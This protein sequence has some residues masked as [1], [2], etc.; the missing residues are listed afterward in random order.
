[1]KSFVRFS[2][3]K[4]KFVILF[5]LLVMTV[6][7]LA[8]Q[9]Q[10]GRLEG[11]VF[12]SDGKP[13]GNITV[14]VRNSTYGT[15]TDNL[16]NF[17]FDVPVGEHVL[18]IFSINAHTIEY[19]VTVPEGVVRIDGIY[20]R[21]T[22]HLLPA[23]VVTG[24][25]SPQSLRSSVYKVRVITNDKIERKSAVDV[26]S[27]LNTEIGIR[28]NNDQTLGETD[29]EVMGMSGNNIK[30]LMDGVPLIDRGDAKQSLSQV[31][32]NSI[33]RI[34]I[35]E[36]PMSVVYGTDALA[37]VVNII[38]KRPSG[39]TT[40]N[41]VSVSAGFQEESVGR[42]YAFF[43]GKG[44][45]TENIYL[46]WEGINGIYA[47]TGFTRN[48][49][50]G[51]RGD[52]SGQEKEW[53]PKSQFLYTGMTGYTNRKLDVWYKLDFVDEKINTPSN[54]TSASPNVVSNKKFLTHRYTNQLHADYRA[55]NRL[56]FNFAASY[57][58]YRRVT[59]TIITDQDTN[60]KWLSLAESSQ[61]TSKLESWF[62][63]LTASW[64]V[65][66]KIK[67]QPGIEYQW[68][69]AS[70]DRV[71][72]SPSISDL[73]IFILAEWTPVEWWNLRPG[74]RSVIISDY[75]A[76]VAI[77]ALLTKL[78]ITDRMDFR[79]SYAY[80]FRAPALRELYFSFHN[81]NHN[82]DGNPDLKSE[83]SHNFTASFTWRPIHNETV[84]LTSSFSGFYNSFKDRITL[85]VDM[86]DPQHMTYYNIDKYRT[87]GGTIENVLSWNNLRV[88]LGISIIGRYNT[89]Y[90]DQRYDAENMDRL[91][92]SPEV[93]AS[94]AYSFRRGTDI[95]FF[96]KFTGKRREYYVDDYG[97]L[98]LGG[99]NS[100]SWADFTVTHRFN[101][102]LSI[103]GGVKN[104]F[105]VTTVK[106]SA[107]GD[108]H[109]EGRVPLLQGYG[110]SYF[111][112]MNFR[113][114]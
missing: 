72:G 67:I 84:R 91:R 31:D 49:H 1:M 44:V 112:G 80:G 34:E 114:N 107:G 32:I 7:S 76:P 41:K 46:R 24:Q 85:A 74:L 4:Y 88:E 103:K 38:T 12:T 23:V 53:S 77:P 17:S 69:K 43:G 2:V 30:I 40:D 89:L 35:V 45:H 16:G 55:G 106:N 108:M 33:D 50:G 5:F 57:Q 79:A 73:A 95:S 19:P 92:Y 111:F 27:L 65:S 64:S 18:E 29:F 96:Y 20:L 37:G 62:T 101:T 21:E 52:K 109:S 3:L 66:P 100:F 25:F 56:S 28:L 6:S 70:G 47:N 71:E 10:P 59:R 48:I 87:A 75:D 90:S 113:F 78:N 11:T 60:E 86:N 42:E 22:S 51:W 97:K 93:A 82:I 8:G 102:H 63:R 54:G 61:D 104:I 94:A 9:S 58:N 98:F 68:N 81:S 83:Y 15:V 14:C 26:Q 110:R 105:N 39:T 99:L 13:A 36:G